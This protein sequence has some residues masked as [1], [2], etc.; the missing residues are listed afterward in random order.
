MARP[1]VDEN[2]KTVETWEITGNSTVWVWVYD[3]RED[4]YIKQRVGGR[5]G[6]RRLHIRRDDRKFNQEQVVDEN[7]THDPFTNGAL[8]LVDGPED[9]DVDRTYHWTLDDFKKILSL[10][11]EAFQ[12]AV[13]GI[14]SELIVRRLKD[15]AEKHGQVWQLEFLR[16]HVEE[17]YKAGGSQ[18][19]VREMIAAGE[20][21][22]QTLY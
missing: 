8:R 18:K 4:K 9:T 16:T 17:H 1:E 2:D 22:G 6:S 13:E 7:K 5:A 10:G 12:E 21:L 14:T 3:K 19:A 11:E 20:D 15:V